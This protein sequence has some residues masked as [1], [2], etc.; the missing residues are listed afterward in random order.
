[1]RSDKCEAVT[2]WLCTKKKHIG[3]VLES[4]T[5]VD[6]ISKVSLLLQERYQII[7]GFHLHT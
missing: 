3:T 4:T 7:I 1:M 6:Q 2:K 5:F